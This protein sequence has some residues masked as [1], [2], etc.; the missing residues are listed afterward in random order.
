MKVK[1]GA[2]FVVKRFCWDNVISSEG[3]PRNPDPGTTYCFAH[4]SGGSQDCLLSFN[5]TH[6]KLSVVDQWDIMEK[7][8]KDVGKVEPVGGR[9]EGDGGGAGFPGP[10]ATHHPVF[11]FTVPLFFQCP[12]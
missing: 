8:G 5:W 12:D 10:G 3:G 1:G 9:T 2:R 4:D 6:S 11:Y 7:E